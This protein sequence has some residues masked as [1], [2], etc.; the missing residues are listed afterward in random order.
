VESL[1]PEE[2][3]IKRDSRKKKVR[4]HFSLMSFGQQPST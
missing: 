4:R 1:E 3:E 2:A